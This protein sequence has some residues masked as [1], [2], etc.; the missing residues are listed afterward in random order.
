LESAPGTLS[1]AAHA[2]LGLTLYL[3][4]AAL[5]TTHR[6]LLLGE[7][8]TLPLFNIKVEL[9]PFYIIAPLLYLVFHFSF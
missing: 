7:P 5:A 4:I 9:L 3:V 6:N 8:Q 1:S 2:F